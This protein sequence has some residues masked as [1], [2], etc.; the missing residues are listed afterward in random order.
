M[1]TQVVN[2]KH[3]RIQEA[4]IYKQDDPR[5]GQLKTRDE[6]RSRQRKNAINQEGHNQIQ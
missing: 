1:M 4:D 3:T 5:N 6:A 2:P